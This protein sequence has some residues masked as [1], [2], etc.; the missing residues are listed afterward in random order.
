MSHLQS[1]PASLAGRLHEFAGHPLHA[2]L[3]AAALNVPPAHA[4]HSPPSAPEKP[5][6]QRQSLGSVLPAGEDEYAGHAVAWSRAPAQYAFGAHAAQT[7]CRPGTTQSASASLPVGELDPAGQAVHI[8]LP[9]AGLYV[10]A[11]HKAHGPPGS[12]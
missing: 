1:A 7:C 12:P 10:S 5:A 3:P 2:A 6:S 11:G 8:P 4:A 9:R